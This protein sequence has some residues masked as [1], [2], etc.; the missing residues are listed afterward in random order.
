MNATGMGVIV[1]VI[2]GLIISIVVIK[3]CNKN[4][5]FKTE[6]DERQ[7]ALR[8]RGYKYAAYTAWIMMGLCIVLD[9]NDVNLHMDNNLKLFTIF[10][11]SI[12][13]SVCF[14]IWNDA[15][16]GR[17]NNT[18]NYVIFMVVITLINL[19]VTV[20]AIE[21]HL[22]IVDGML[23]WRAMNLECALIFIIVGILYVVKG[24]IS[25]SGEQEAEE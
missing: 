19:L 15:Y 5:K 24:I 9:L 13:V 17:N 21:E 25:K 4:G 23:T 12:M 3:A 20:V 8:G 1:G 11:V 7:E 16:W 2:V 10:F 18:K 14:F 22:L 6:Y